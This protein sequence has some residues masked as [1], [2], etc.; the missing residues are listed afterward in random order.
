MGRIDELTPYQIA[1]VFPEECKEYIPRAIKGFEVKIIQTRE[2]Y[3]RIDAMPVT[4]GLKMLYRMFID[5]G[6]MQRYRQLIDKYRKTMEILKDLEIKKYL[7]NTHKIAKAKARPIDTFVTLDK[8]RMGTARI[9]GCCPLGT[10]ADS[11]PSFVIYRHTN[12]W[13]C[14]SC[15]ESGDSIALFMKINDCEFGKALEELSR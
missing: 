2:S 12:T 11:N 4:P 13:H 1:D 10:H 3:A 9:H 5:S 6:E 14:F 8:Q 15:K 7:D